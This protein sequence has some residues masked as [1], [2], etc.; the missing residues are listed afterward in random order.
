MCTSGEAAA[1]L[2]N[3]ICVGRLRLNVLHLSANKFTGLGDILVEV[4][5]EQCANWLPLCRPES[6]AKVMEAPVLEVCVEPTQ[7][8]PLTQADRTW[9]WYTALFH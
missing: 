7:V 6:F 4:A 9:L 8:E 5:H 1:S 2:T 3:V